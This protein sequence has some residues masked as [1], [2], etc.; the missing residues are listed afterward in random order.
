MK[1]HKFLVNWIETY[2]KNRDIVAKQIEKIEKNVG[3]FDLIIH[4]KTG[5]IKIII[6]KEILD[7]FEHILKDFDEEDPNTEHVLVILNNKEN[8]RKT[9][10]K[11]NLLHS[12][13]N[14]VI[15]FINP[16][17]KTDTKWVIYPHT[18][19][20]I[21]EQPALKS[22]LES[23]SLNVEYITKEELEKLI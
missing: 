18:H 11:W 19:H 5:K 13:V 4:H 12:R 16:F 7:D 17:S 15:Y 9:V 23:L 21:T 20:R 22:G 14:L 8:I 3:K 10:E 2:F 6:I 1:L